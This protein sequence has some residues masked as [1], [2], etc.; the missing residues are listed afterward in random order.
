MASRL[1]VY[2]TTAGFYETVVAAANQSEALKAWG[3]RQNLFAEGA[4]DIENDPDIVDM[5][6]AHPGQPLRRPIGSKQAFKL[7][8]DAPPTPKAGKI[9]AAPKVDRGALDAAEQALEQLEHRQK[10]EAADLERRKEALEAERDAAEARWADDR[11]I[12]TKDVARE[13]KAYAKAGGK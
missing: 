7:E 6:S 1:K 10:K 12:A 13:R 2:R 9:S 11:D 5:A 8:P 4:A 3:V